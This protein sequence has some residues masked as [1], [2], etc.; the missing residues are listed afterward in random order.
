[1]A[2]LIG[3]NPILLDNASGTEKSFSRL[4]GDTT[5]STYIDTDDSGIGT[6]VYMTFKQQVSKDKNGIDVQ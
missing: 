6:P 3:D 2:G 5:Q 1:M 4:K